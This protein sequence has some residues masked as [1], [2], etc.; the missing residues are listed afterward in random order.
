MKI[1]TYVNF[2][3]KGDDGLDKILSDINENKNKKLTFIQGVDF[4][5]NLVLERKRK[6]EAV[7]YIHADCGV[8]YLY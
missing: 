7:H 4:A 2:F 6:G 1:A 8:R 5:R 3:F